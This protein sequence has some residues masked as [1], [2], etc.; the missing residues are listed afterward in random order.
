MS[1]NADK[2]LTF[3]P[4]TVKV[5]PHPE[6]FRSPNDGDSEIVKGS[7]EKFIDDFLNNRISELIKED[8]LSAESGNFRSRLL[9][10]LGAEFQLQYNDAESTSDNVDDPSINTDSGLK[11]KINSKLSELSIDPK[12]GLTAEHIMVRVGALSCGG[13]HQYS[14]SSKKDVAP[15]IQWPAAAGIGFVHID[16]RGNLSPALLEAFLPERKLNMTTFSTASQPSGLSGIRANKAATQV[17]IQS[18]LAAKSRVE[19]LIRVQNLE[20]NV[21]QARIIDSL[22][23]GAFRPSRRAH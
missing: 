19:A 6:L 22:T 13:C 14:P 16:E 7:R 9:H 18:I 20:N 2:S 15:G 8:K 10:K 5:N 4:V 12:C 3:V 11:S 21:E 17:N 23:P 1:L